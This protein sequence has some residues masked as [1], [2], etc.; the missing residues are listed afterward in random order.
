MPGVSWRSLTYTCCPAHT[1]AKPACQARSRRRRGEWVSAI[2]A[3]GAE[4]ALLVGYAGVDY[5]DAYR[6][7]CLLKSAKL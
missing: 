3:L 1:P 5:S 4:P 6:R 2:E 7:D